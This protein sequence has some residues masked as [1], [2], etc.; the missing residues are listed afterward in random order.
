[1]AKRNILHFVKVFTKTVLFC[2]FF[3]VVNHS[4]LFKFKFKFKIAQRIR[5]FYTDNS[6]NT[7]SARLFIN[8]SVAYSFIKF[9]NLFTNEYKTTNSSISVCACVCM[10]VCSYCMEMIFKFAHNRTGFRFARTWFF[11]YRECVCGSH[12]HFSLVRS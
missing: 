9:F 5:L 10:Y 4:K 6:P 1:M 3:F 12:I 2:A 7:Y 11:S 8:S